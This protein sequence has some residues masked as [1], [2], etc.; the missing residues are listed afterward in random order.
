MNWIFFLI[1]FGITMDM[2]SIHL[3][4]NQMKSASIF[5]PN[6]GQLTNIDGQPNP[7]ILYTAS[8]GGVQLFVLKDR[9]AIQKVMPL[10]D[11]NQKAPQENTFNSYRTDIIWIGMH[12]D[13]KIEG[14]H[15]GSNY[16]NYY[17]AHTPPEG[18]KNVYGY[19]KLKFSNIYPN[20]DLW[21]SFDQNKARFKYE[22]HVAPGADIQNIK[23][24]YSDKDHLE[25]DRQGNIIVQTPLGNF[26]E[27]APKSFEDGA[28]IESF[29]IKNKDTFSFSIP[30]RTPHQMLIIDPEIEWGTYLG[31]ANRDYENSLIK[32]H[33][34]LYTSFSTYSS[35]LALNGFQMNLSGQIDMLIMKIN[36]K[37]K[38]IIWSTYF[39]G[40]RF[41]YGFSLIMDKYSDFYLSGITESNNGIGFNGFQNTKSTT[42]RDRDIFIL[43]LDTNGQRIWSTYYGGN[44]KEERGNVILSNDHEHFYLI[45]ST[46]ST[47]N[48]ASPNSP[49]KSNKSLPLIDYLQDIF[50]VKFNKNGA[51][52]WGTYYGSY[53]SDELYSSFI[54]TNDQ[55]HILGYTFNVT[56]DSGIILAPYFNNAFVPSANRQNFFAKF[57]ANG[58]L[59]MGTFI[60]LQGV[61]AVDITKHNNLLYQIGYTTTTTIAGLNKFQNSNLTQYPTPPLNLNAIVFCTDTNYNLIWGSFFGGSL[62]ETFTQ[63]NIINDTLHLFGSSSSPEIESRLKFENKK[64]GNDDLIHVKLTMQGDL[65]SSRYYGGNLKDLMGTTIYEYPKMY[66]TGVT[67]STTGIAKN[68]IQNLYAGGEDA[69]IVKYCNSASFDTTVASICQGDSFF[70]QSKWHKN[71]GTFVYAYPNF[72]GCDS[73]KVLILQVNNPYKK[74]YRH[75]LCRGQRIQIGNQFYS[76]SDS[77]VLKYA[78]TFGC[79][80]QEN[81]IILVLDTLFSKTDTFYLCSI[82]SITDRQNSGLFRQYHTS[83][84]GCDSIYNYFIKINPKSYSRKDTTIC[85]GQSYR[86]YTTTGLYIDTFVNAFMC[87]SVDSLFLFVYPQ[88]SSTTI[89]RMICQGD[90]IKWNNQWLYNSGQYFDTI[91]NQNGCDSI[92]IL[93]LLLR[94]VVPPL[95]IPDTV[96]CD[97]DSVVFELS[98]AY[99]K[100]SWST[101]DTIYRIVIKEKG[102]FSVIVTDTNRCSQ[103]DTFKV[104]FSDKPLIRI[105]APSEVGIGMPTLLDAQGGN[106]LDSSWYWTTNQKLSC[107][108][109]KKPTVTA[110]TSFWIRLDYKDPLGCKAMDS[111]WINAVLFNDF[112]GFPTAFSPNNDTKND[113]FWPQGRDVASYDLQIYNRWGEKIFDNKNSSLGWNG[114]YK[115]LYV[116]PGVYLYTYS[117][118]MK[119]GMVFSGKAYIQVMK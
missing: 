118:K 105:K 54:D 78:S 92:V 99:S 100:V 47:N 65:I 58:Q 38:N 83:F 39:G 96:V 107:R 77:L 34:H 87:D 9:I 3:P 103:K 21:L 60:P 6:V 20:I 23:W 30:N 11:S 104:N 71:K 91:K 111:L 61:L 48:I 72:E 55:I 50:I 45:S 64:I 15:K 18:I 86:G 28:E 2:V 112:F 10:I 7:E 88:P 80:S 57:N 33:Q 75:T 27:P 109:C 97:G 22:W 5:I 66:F 16:F 36:E 44:L 89:N 62:S 69:F 95:S 68:G 4:D 19:E 59:L 32:H 40:E 114:K 14:I 31:G 8:K 35:G 37:N 63:L 85:F 113:T 52:I 116:E 94:K 53:G 74:T 73:S 90:S 43:K 67:T 108:R 79:D 1:F 70:F 25:I 26:I 12:K 81:H 41:D 76:N 117:I 93:E 82:D 106:N 51:R 13:M 56:S 24:I 29:F 119:T 101:K 102:Q 98:K 110:E 115:G 84:Q 17:L 42:G 49:H 46:E